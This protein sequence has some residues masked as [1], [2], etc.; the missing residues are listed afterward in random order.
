MKSKDQTV[1]F[2]LN[3]TVIIVGF[4]L[5]STRFLALQ[6]PLY[7]GL[8]NFQLTGGDDIVVVD[9]V[10]VIVVVVISSTALTT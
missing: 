3:V 4:L 2:L 8:C 7:I 1:T 10:V 5:F 9:I 6:T